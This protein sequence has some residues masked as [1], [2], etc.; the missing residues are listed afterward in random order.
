MKRSLGIFAILAAADFAAHAT[1]VTIDAEVL[2]DSF[3]AAMPVSG[4]VILT[5]G[6]SG[7]FFGPTPTSFIS[8]DE[9][10]LKKWDLTGGFATA[11]MLQETTGDLT[12]SGAWN[13]GDPLR[14]YWYP[15]LTL[16]AAVPEAGTKYG[17]YR[18]GV[19]IDGGAAWITGGPSDTISLKF[20]TADATVLNA[21]GS[22][23]ANSGVANLTVGSVPE[24]G[25]VVLSLVALVAMTG[26]Q[27]RRARVH[28]G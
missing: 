27:R 21:G 22:N 26:I 20:F 25:T 13:A 14:L 19:G 7:N 18:D 17:T 2:K 9:I 23:A 11:G 8:G 4:L 10:V 16:A 12:L 28:V 3:G 5:A 15:T 24:P 1:T 6:T